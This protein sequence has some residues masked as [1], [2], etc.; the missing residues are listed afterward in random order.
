[1]DIKKHFDRYFEQL[2]KVPENIKS[3]SYF[4]KFF[5][6]RI[7]DLLNTSISDKKG[8]ALLDILDDIE[9]IQQPIK[10]KLVIGDE[11]IAWKEDFG[12]DYQNLIYECEDRLG[13][14]FEGL[15]YADE[16]GDLC[17][18]VGNDDLQLLISANQLKFHVL[19]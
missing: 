14:K 18:L 12:L 9:D 19:N 6:F 17:N 1:M 16:S 13:Y 15:R 7:G 5:K 4:Q 10:V 11:I 2:V 8:D 3:S